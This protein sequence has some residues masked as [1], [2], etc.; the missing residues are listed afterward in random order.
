M[1]TFSGIRSL[2]SP[3]FSRMRYYE[4]TCR[5]DIPFY[6][7]VRVGSMLR[8]TDLR[9]ILRYVPRFRDKVFV[10][11]LD[12]AV[13]EDDNFANLLLDIRSEEHTS[14]L[15]SHSDLVCRLL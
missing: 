12:G 4:L 15:Q 5:Q 11:A 10:I 13:I 14:E 7:P 2:P 1:T 6:R 3:C 9:E 8:L